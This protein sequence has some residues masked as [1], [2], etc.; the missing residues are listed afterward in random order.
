MTREEVLNA[1]KQCVCSD[2]ESQYGNP[3][4][5]FETI[6]DFW[7]VYLEAAD[8]LLSS[9]E[10]ADVAAMMGL[11]KLA[12]IAIGKNKSDNWIDLA[13]YAACGGEI[14]GGANGNE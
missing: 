13:G 3:E 14:Q 11:L 9:I 8:K 1:A 2:R 4:S 6:A 12:R 10:A 7:N 5:N